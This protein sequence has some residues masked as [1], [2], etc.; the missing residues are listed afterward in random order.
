MKNIILFVGVAGFSLLSPATSHAAIVFT[1]SAASDSSPTVTLTASGSG[2]IITTVGNWA[3]ERT[4]TIS[5]I[6]GDPF[7]ASFVSFT[8]GNALTGT[9]T[10][11]NGS[12][13][14]TLNNFGLDHDP[15]TN[16]DDLYLGWASNPNFTVSDTITFSGSAT[17]NISGFGATFGD[18]TKG[19]Y[20]LASATG[21][22]KFASEFN[23]SDFSNGL[24]IVPEPEEYG[25]I[26]G[27][28]AVGFAMVRRIREKRVAIAS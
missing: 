25:A 13:S 11:S 1:L 10:A 12:I 15:G 20:D 27:L 9:I 18:M 26:L 5:N 22:N 19:T 14:T 2:T 21:F 4:Y 24:V 23:S 17:V 7:P 28:A 3:R 6:P 16:A 8:T